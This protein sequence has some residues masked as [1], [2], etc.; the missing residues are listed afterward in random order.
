MK[1]KITV[2]V[3]FDEE[4]SVALRKLQTL[5]V[6]SYRIMLIESAEQRKHYAND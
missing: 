4:P 3:E 1:T 6:G 2:E 5:L